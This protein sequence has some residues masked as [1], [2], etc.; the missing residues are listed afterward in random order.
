[1]KL[2]VLRQTGSLMSIHGQDHRAPKHGV[3]TRVQYQLSEN[4]RPTYQLQHPG[5]PLF[6]ACRPERKTTDWKGHRAGRVTLAEGVPPALWS[7]S[8]VLHLPS[9][10]AC[11]S[12]PAPPGSPGECAGFQGP[13]KWAFCPGGCEGRGDRQSPTGSGQHALAS[14]RRLTLTPTPFPG[15]RPGGRGALEASAPAAI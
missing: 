13:G 10:L 11:G 6:T 12:W 8:H 15:R 4:T 7:P 9:S 3:G 2:S 14:A 1:M 5:F